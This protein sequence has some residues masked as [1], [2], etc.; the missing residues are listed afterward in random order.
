LQHLRIIVHSIK[1]EA[2]QL[3]AYADGRLC[4]PD[5]EPDF[6]VIPRCQI[7]GAVPLS[8]DRDKTCL[9]H[10]TE[11]CDG[12]RIIYRKGINASMRYLIQLLRSN[13]ATKGLF[14]CISSRL[15]PLSS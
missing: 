11:P 15:K 1:R 12:T 6:E 9:Y 7:V 8:V 10:K 3:G 13:G 2:S 4:T 14:C 5:L